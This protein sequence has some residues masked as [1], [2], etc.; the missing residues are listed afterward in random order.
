[1]AGADVISVGSQRGAGFSRRGALDPLHERLAK[2][3]RR[4][5]L[6]ELFQP[7]LR[8]PITQGVASQTQKPG[9]L[10]FVAVSAL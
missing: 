7:H 5:G 8:Q 2:A 10:A 1:M 4:L 9:S 6:E 3:N